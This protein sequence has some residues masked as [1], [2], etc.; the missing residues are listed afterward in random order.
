[1][2]LRH[3]TC[4]F[5]CQTCILVMTSHDFTFIGSC[6]REPQ[7]YSSSTSVLPYALCFSWLGLAAVLARSIRHAWPSLGLASADCQ[8]QKLTWWIILQPYPVDL[9]RIPSVFPFTAVSVSSTH[10]SSHVT[11]SAFAW[12]LVPGVMISYSSRGPARLLTAP[13]PSQILA[14]R[15]RQQQ[16]PQLSILQHFGTGLLATSRP[17]LTPICLPLAAATAASPTRP[18]RRSRSR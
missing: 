10:I 15:S 6:F 3:V 7:Q 11:A 4:I 5:R 13:L 1:M 2:I 12:H 18:A 14:L 8:P 16:L 17:P 9:H